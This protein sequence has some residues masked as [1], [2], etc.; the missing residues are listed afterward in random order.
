MI[1]LLHFI[2][3]VPVHFLPAVWQTNDIETLWTIITNRSRLSHYNKLLGHQKRY[4]QCNCGPPLLIT[5]SA[6]F[7]R[8]K[9]VDWKLRMRCYCI[10]WMQLCATD[11]SENLTMCILGFSVMLFIR[12]KILYLPDLFVCYGKDFH[13]YL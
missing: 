10:Y 5:L 11:S 13:D 4:L 6:T 7:E 12:S 3:K 9:N 2:S 1:F 8:G